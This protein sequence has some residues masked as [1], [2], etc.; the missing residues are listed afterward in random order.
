MSWAI[1]TRRISQRQAGGGR[2]Q[3]DQLRTGSACTCDPARGTV[4]TTS[5]KVRGIEVLAYEPGDRTQAAITL[6]IS[7]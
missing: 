6:K 5:G 4:A 1:H 3:R 7:E 2:L